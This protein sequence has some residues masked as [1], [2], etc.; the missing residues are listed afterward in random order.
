MIYFF[1]EIVKPWINYVIVIGQREIDSDILPVR[2]RQIG[3]IRNMRLQ[4][5]IDEIKK[6]TV[7]KPFQS[8]TLPRE[9]SK[10]PQF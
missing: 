3:K 6:K 5:L 7:D 2:D 8:L 10:R 1:M 9:L 4:Q